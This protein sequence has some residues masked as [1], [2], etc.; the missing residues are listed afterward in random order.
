MLCSSQEG[1]KRF[2]LMSKSSKVST[3][4]SSLALALLKIL[5][6]ITL[7]TNSLLDF[8][9]IMDWNCANVAKNLLFTRNSFNITEQFRSKFLTVLLRENREQFVE[10]FL[11]YGFQLHKFLNPSQL[12]RL[13]RLIHEDDF[14]QT[15]CWESALGH[16]S[17]A[18]QGKFFIES[19]LNWLI[20][21]CTGLDSFV[22]SGFG[23]SNFTIGVM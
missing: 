20:E 22:N 8:D 19:D 13:F 15:V 14:F 12:N 5:K 17:S 6:F 4:I 9:L 23:S 18:K 7:N 21:F 2:P 16:S 1:T 3:T 10:I 11:S